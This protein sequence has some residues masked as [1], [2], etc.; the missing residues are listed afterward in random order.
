MDPLKIRKWNSIRVNGKKYK[1][2][3]IAMLAQMVCLYS[4]PLVGANNLIGMWCHLTAIGD[5]MGP[6][7]SS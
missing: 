2:P 1:K 5:G 4:L 6:T 7:I 3:V